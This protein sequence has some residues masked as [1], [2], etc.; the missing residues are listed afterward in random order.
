MPKFILTLVRKILRRTI[1]FSS[2][3]KR[4]KLR[5]PPTI[6]LLLRIN[7]AYQYTYI[8]MWAS[9]R[10]KSRHPDTS[11]CSSQSVCSSGCRNT[12]RCCH[13]CSC[14]HEPDHEQYSLANRRSQ[15]KNGLNVF[16]FT[17]A[18]QRNRKPLLV[19]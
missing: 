7:L 2:V 16:Y 17:G 18:K 3:L 12:S 1:E 9:S 14:F 5:V 13:S 10:S 11:V 8:R 19:P 15:L 6:L 4:I